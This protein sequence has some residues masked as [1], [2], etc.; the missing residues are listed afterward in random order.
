MSD[1]LQGTQ[2]GNIAQFLT[3]LEVSAFGELMAAEKRPVVQINA[4]YGLRDNVRT[5]TALSGVATAS[6]GLFRASTGTTANATSEITSRGILVYRSGQGAEGMLTALF[7]EGVA[8]F[9]SCAGLFSP[10]DGYCF[11]YVGV[12]FGIIHKHH[13]VLHA[14]L[15][16]L[17]VAAAAAE[18]A[19][20]TIDGTAYTVPLS[21]VGTLAG[22]ADEIQASLSTQLPD[23]RFTQNGAT[24]LGHLELSEVVAGAFA[25]SSATST[26]TWANV[27]VGAEPTQVFYP[28]G[29]W[30]R[31]TLPT[32][33]Q[34][35]LN[36][37]QINY[38]YLGAGTVHFA[39]EDPKTGA[40]TLVHTIEWPN[41]NTEPSLG[42]PSFRI[43]WAAKST[44]S[45]TDLGVRGASAMAAQQG[46]DGNTIRS[47][48]ADA[49]QTVTTVEQSHITF[50]P[51]HIFGG[52]HNH[53]ETAP[54]VVN[55]ANDG[56]KAC[57]VRVYGGLQITGQQNFAYVDEAN[58]LM[59]ISTVQSPISGTPV[60][61]VSF[62]VAKGGDKS[63]DLTALGIAGHEGDMFTVTTQMESGAAAVVSV[64]TLWKERT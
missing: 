58:S 33:K 15:L 51:R 41:A 44:G 29:E 32:L 63:F 52:I 55:V 39:V 37:Y 47:E 27:A 43:G 24:V 17:T 40:F 59:E 4:V 38:Q 36:V 21:G 25:Y 20:V 48:T 42:N 22:D 54:I 56:S 50:R 45:T 7:D 53:G 19:T 28:Q 8:N 10:T 26:G 11:G 13:G 62:P 12:D 5:T 35:K 3:D 16:T 61:F 14:E 6:E 34:A 23:W 18:N 1:S 30:N 2:L 46:I 64:S 49:N 57:I 9:E 31:N 60:P